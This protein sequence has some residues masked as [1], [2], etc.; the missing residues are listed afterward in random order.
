MERSGGLH[1]VDSVK[2]TLRNDRKTIAW[3][4][5]RKIKENTVSMEQF[6]VKFILLF[7]RSVDVGR[8]AQ[9]REP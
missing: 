3:K 4:T 1:T 5:E 9:A 7:I 2:V 6:Q 8:E